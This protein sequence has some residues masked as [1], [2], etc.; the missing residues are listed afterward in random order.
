MSDTAIELRHKAI[1]RT[2]AQRAGTPSD[3]G[4]VAAPL[5]STWN[6]IAVR[7]APVIGWAGVH[8][9]LGRA[10]QIASK[11]VP[12]LLPAEHSGPGAGQLDSLLAALEAR[13][14]DTA[15]EASYVLLATLTDL[16]ASLIG[17][18]LTDQ[19][20]DPVWSSPPD[21]HQKESAP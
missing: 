21:S 5:I 3:A 19:L 11:D 6:Q 15:A 12:W 17:N 18:T 7:L 16:L 4:G 9:L 14:S 10:R 2:L 13:D 1:R 8:I 20:L